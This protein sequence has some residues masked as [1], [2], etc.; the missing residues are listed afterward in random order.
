MA[1][2]VAGG[3]GGGAPAGGSGGGAPSG[4]GGGAVSSP[5]APAGGAAASSVATPGA[6]AGQPTEV[7]HEPLDGESTVAALTRVQQ[8]ASA[9]RKTEAE[10]APIVPADGSQPKIDDPNAPPIVEGTEGAKPAADADAGAVP[11]IDEEPFTLDDR[12]DP[13]LPPKQLYKQL[14]DTPEGKA[15]AEAHPELLDRI[16]AQSR[17]VTRAKDVL[18]IVRTK[19]E[20][21]QAVNMAEE[22]AELTEMFTGATDLEKNKQFLNRLRD[23][24]LLRDEEGN[25]LKDAQGNVQSTGAVGRFLDFTLDTAFQFWKAQATKDPANPDNELLAAIDAFQARRGRGPA[26]AEREDDLTPTQKAA[27]AQINAEKETLHQQRIEARAADETKFENG[28]QSAIESSVDSEID[29]ILAKADLGTNDPKATR[30]AIKSAIYGKLKGNRRFA[31]ERDRLMANPALSKTQEQKR[32]ALA[33]GWIK[34][35]LR[36]TAR[37][38]MNKVGAKLIAKQDAVRERA[39]AGQAASRSETRGGGQPPSP[40]GALTQDQLNE[41]TVADWKASHDGRSPSTPEFLA[42]YPAVRA[43]LMTGR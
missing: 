41:A 30:D 14:T 35:S 28:V 25:P 20:A 16:M 1:D 19:E 38:E 18:D 39:A 12:P 24:D 40:Q 29:K 31:N 43:R 37:A 36:D 15:L 23:Y 4:G 27:Q 5:A 22:F 7:H 2:E 34:P 17:I 42:H 21:Q 13:T 3:A 10:A 32:V 8:E 33:M 26:A 11:D 6:G 9:L